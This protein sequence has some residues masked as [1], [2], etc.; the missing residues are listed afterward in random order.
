MGGRPLDGMIA[1]D[2]DEGT[3]SLSMVNHCSLI[4]ACN[5]SVQW[6]GK[7]GILHTVKEVATKDAAQSQG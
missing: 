1:I 5:V 3:P 7:Q 6:V 2:R 4:A